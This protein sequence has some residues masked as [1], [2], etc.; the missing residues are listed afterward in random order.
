[1]RLLTSFKIERGLRTYGFSDLTEGVDFILEETSDGAVS[2]RKIGQSTERGDVLVKALAPILEHYA[3][4]GNLPLPPVKSHD[5]ALDDLVTL[6][7]NPEIFRIAKIF[8]GVEGGGS[9]HLLLN[10][11]AGT[12]HGWEDFQKIRPI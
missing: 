5:F 3:Q 4:Y 11:A 7:E 1:M 8:H 12:D 2:I 9:A 10:D 6:G